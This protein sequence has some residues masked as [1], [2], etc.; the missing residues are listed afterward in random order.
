MKPEELAAQVGARMQVITADGKRLGKVRHVHT[1]ETAVYV[2]VPP[3]GALWVFK[4][5]VFKIKHLFLPAS[6][7][8]EVVGN[9]VHINMDAQTANGCTARP[10]WIEAKDFVDLGPLGPLGGGGFG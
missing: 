4:L 10:R 7:V 3:A 9:R 8:V 5:W 6:A 1:Y 2:E